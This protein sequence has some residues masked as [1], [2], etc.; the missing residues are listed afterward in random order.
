MRELKK[1]DSPLTN[2]GGKSKTQ[3]G[4][5]QDS[6][7]QKEWVQ[8]RQSESAKLVTST[9]MKRQEMTSTWGNRIELDAER[10]QVGGIVSLLSKPDTGGQ[11]D[12][13]ELKP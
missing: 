6:L 11:K 13:G 1:R 4:L 3:W 8:K 5:N 10:K 12:I 7:G 2:K 9:S